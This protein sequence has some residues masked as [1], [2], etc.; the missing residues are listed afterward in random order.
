MTEAANRTRVLWLMK[1][2]GPGG[3]ERLL[4]EHARGHAEADFSYDVA[5]VLRAKTHLVPALESCG[6][7][8]QALGVDRE[9]DP[10]WVL[11]LRRLLRGGRFD[12]V[13]AHSPLPASVARLLVRAMPRATRPRFV[14]TEHNRW[15]SHHA[16]TRAANRATFSLNDAIFAVSDDVRESIDARHRGTVEVLTHGIDLDAVRAHASDRDAV[17]TELGVGDGVALAVTVANLRATKN[18]PG[19]LEAA[20]AVADRGLP[21][22][23]AAAGQGPLATEV[24]AEH[25]RLGLGDTF[26]LLGYRTDATR[27]IAAA[28]VYVLASHHEGLPV[29]VMEALALG[30]PVVA[31]AVGGLPEVV[32]TGDNGIL[33]APGDAGALAA[34]I[35][36][37]L[38]PPEHARLVI[39]ARASGDRFSNAAAIARLEQTY[40]DLT[41]RR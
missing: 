2:L 20:R 6:V 26:R 40:R 15:Q 13:H 39:G 41:I 35:E 14:Y 3:A 10:R 21:V 22:R 30:V 32:R 23:F 31:P 1:G 27:L 33:V 25:D 5:Y 36:R 11:R 38:S 24:Q 8:T 37:A 7:T 12:V 18:Y 28:D 29:T 4:V 9:L 34:A 16:L 17:R 19:L